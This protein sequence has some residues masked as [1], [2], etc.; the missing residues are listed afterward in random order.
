MKDLILINNRFDENLEAVIRNP[1]SN[2]RFPVVVFVPGIGATMHETKNSHDEIA[3]VLCD[4]G[5]AAVQFSFAGRGKSEGKYEDMT[6]SRLAAQ[7]ED[8][9]AWV[10]T[11]D[12]ADP[13]RIGIYAMSFGVATT[14]KALTE[15]I[16]SFCLVSGAYNPYESL[17]SLFS[18]NGEV[19]EEGISWRK[20]SN[21]DL[22]RL[23]SGFWSD[24]K[25]FD[26]APALTN[27]RK[28]VFIIHGKADGKISYSEAEEAFSLIP[29]DNKKLELID[30]GD[31]GIIDVPHQTRQHFLDTMV[32]WFEK[33]V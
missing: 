5:F 11:Q 2:G 7:L 29:S 12:F 18:K 20:F 32:E 1:N 19:H 25:T 17:K 4:A 15:E 13:E 16:A 14:L 10:T 26:S 24:L 22:I 23:K 28:P 27:I 6:L 9:I 3:K 21:G 8:V 30:G 31:H 33:T